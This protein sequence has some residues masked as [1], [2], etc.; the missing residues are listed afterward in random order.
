MGK[1]Q[2]C[3]LRISYKDKIL[4][5]ITAHKI[6][7]INSYLHFAVNAIQIEFMILAYQDIDSFMDS[8]LLANLAENNLLALSRMS[9]QWMIVKFW[10][11]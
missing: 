2:K 3:R 4:I 5:V 6:F 7:Q 8:Y 1:N 11:E 9:L 10:M